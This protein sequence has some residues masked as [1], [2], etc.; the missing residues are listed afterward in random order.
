[1]AR[2]LGE[3]LVD[4]GLITQQQLQDLLEQQEIS[5]KPLGQLLLDTAAITSEDLHKAVVQQFQEK[6]ANTISKYNILVLFD[7]IDNLANTMLDNKTTQSLWNDWL[8]S[9]KNVKVINRKTER[10]FT[11]TLQ[12]LKQPE[13][14]QPGGEFIPIAFN[15][16]ELFIATKPSSSLD[17]IFNDNVFTFLDLSSTSIAVYVVTDEE[18][19]LLVDMYHNIS[20]HSG[21]YNGA[22]GGSEAVSR[23]KQAIEISEAMKVDL[24]RQGIE[25]PTR[26]ARQIA[27]AMLAYVLSI[28]NVTDLHLFHTSEGVFFEYRTDGELVIEYNRGFS[29][30]L[31]KQIA[32]VI[33]QLSGMNYTKKV[34]Q[35]GQFEINYRPAGREPQHYFVRVASAHSVHSMDATDLYLRFLSSKNFDTSLEELGYLPWQVDML[36]A[37]INKPYGIILI[38]GPTGSGKSTTLYAMISHLLK[39]DDKLNILTVEDPV[40]YRL[41]GV[42]QYQID[43]KALSEADRI[44]FPSMLRAAMRMDPDVILIGEIRD[45]ETLDI[46]L[47][48]ALTGH[49][50]FA[51]LHANTAILAIS[52]MINMKAPPDIL[53]ATLNV[54]IGQRLLRKAGVRGRQ[55]IAEI[56]DVSFALKDDIAKG[57]EEIELYH[58]AWLEGF[59]TMEE[60]AQYYIERGIVTAEEV[61][62]TI[63]DEYKQL[64]QQFL[65]QS[66]ALQQPI[67]TQPIIQPRPVIEQQPITQQTDQQLTQPTVQTKSSQ[68][69]N[70]EGADD[71]NPF[72]F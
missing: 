52:R 46:A 17:I 71:E 65:Q 8:E 3:I 64:R 54:I 62:R 2:K 66:G 47:N 31:G 53:A 59:K 50:V 41:D 51:T 45:R 38:T 40:E 20:Q 70:N 14:G 29:A 16:R 18:Y 69:N 32:N 42:K 33:M 34:P 36:H 21:V 9:K 58:T 26:D 22:I 55:A 5:G 11:A 1:M 27:F 37:A 25:Q 72:E 61:Q 67:I 68:T 23:E 7:T 24:P 63:G 43:E 12:A 48:A 49:L 56:L 44:T 19:S 28:P 57:K 60:N 35:D 15:V 30:E 39:R 4:N 13:I 10:A 6:Y